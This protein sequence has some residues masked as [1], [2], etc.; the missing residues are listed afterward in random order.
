[1]TRVPF[2]GAEAYNIQGS[3]VHMR[4]VVAAIEDVAPEVTG[5]IT[6]EPQ[7][8]PFPDGQEDAP[9]RALLGGV[10]HTP[11]KEGVAKSVAAFREALAEGL[12]DTKDLDEGASPK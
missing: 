7:P 2:E 6:F 9:L 8:L 12:L 3:V 5:K 11:L 1:M 10:P 4:E